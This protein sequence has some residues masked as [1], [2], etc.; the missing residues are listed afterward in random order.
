M[1][2]A[3][4]ATTPVLL[5]V[6]TALGRGCRRGGGCKEAWVIIEGSIQTHHDDVDL[7]QETLQLR[8]GQATNLLKSNLLHYMRKEQ[9]GCGARSEDP[10]IPKI[11]EDWP[12]QDL[13]FNPVQI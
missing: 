1:V 9:G 5:K 12:C 11:S 8:P 7:I 2:V 4:V 10:K 3:E 6:G 13:V